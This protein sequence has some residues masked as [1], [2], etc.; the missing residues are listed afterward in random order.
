MMKGPCA[1]LLSPKTSIMG[2]MKELYAAMQE[3]HMA[4]LRI[5]YDIAVKNN[6]PTFW[7][8]GQEM[9]TVYAKYLLE[10]TDTF[11]K[12]FTDDNIRNTNNES[13]RFV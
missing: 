3:G 13:Q 8:Q 7:F 5:A 2:K 1:P 4:T 9:S 12:D 10:F 11:L 6:Q